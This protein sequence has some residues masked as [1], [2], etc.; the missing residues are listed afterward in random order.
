MGGADRLPP[1]G[2]V[3]EAR[4]PLRAW[5][6]SLS[7]R[8]SKPEAEF[9]RPSYLVLILALIFFLFRIRLRVWICV[10]LPALELL[11]SRASLPRPISAAVEL[12]QAVDVLALAFDRIDAGGLFPDPAVSSRSE[13]SVSSTSGVLSNI[14]VMLLI[15]IKEE[16]FGVT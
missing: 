14:G 12:V 10:A 4:A 6:S 5:R 8:G 16:N 13:M 9:S 15:T 2:A 1:Q 7:G 3:A 11:A